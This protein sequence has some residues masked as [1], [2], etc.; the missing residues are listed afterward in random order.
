VSGR[1]D[2]A[3]VDI[4]YSYAGADAPPSTRSCRGR[5]GDRLGVAGSGHD[6]PR[7][8][9]TRSPGRG[10]RAWWSCSPA[11]AGSGRVLPA[12]SCANGAGS[13]A[14]NLFAAEGPHPRDARPHRHR[15]IPPGPADFDGVLS[16]G[17]GLEDPA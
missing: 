3:R 16:L 4:A 5:A 2:L 8:S 10:T 14:D 15:Q 1:R 11:G 6:E 12:P 7:P 9:R 13:S 17:E